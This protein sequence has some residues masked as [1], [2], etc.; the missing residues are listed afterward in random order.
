[1]NRVIGIKKR[2]KFNLLLTKN[3]DSMH[4][5]LSGLL[6]KKAVMVA[7]YPHTMTVFAY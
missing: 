7:F 4:G 6:Q 3:D 5:E 1:M 2:E